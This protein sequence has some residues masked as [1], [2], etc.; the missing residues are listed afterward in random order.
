MVSPSMFPG[1]ALLEL[2]DVP[3]SDLQLPS[4]AP[5]GHALLAR[6][7]NLSDISGLEL[8][9]AMVL[10]PVLAQNPIRLEE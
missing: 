2:G 8:G 3:R 6:L 5:P 1:H 9:G 10:A 7:P 4:D